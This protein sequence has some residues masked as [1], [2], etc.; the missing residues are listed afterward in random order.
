MAPKKKL[1][2]LSFSSLL[3]L[4][5]LLQLFGGCPRKLLRKYLK[6]TLDDLRGQS[7]D[8]VLAV[9]ASGMTQHNSRLFSLSPI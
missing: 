7:V 3:A 4:L 1:L 6:W 8:G 5:W 9:R 2:F